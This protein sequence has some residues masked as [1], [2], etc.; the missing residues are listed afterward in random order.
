MK[1][2][3]GRRNELVELQELYDRKI[4]SLA[5]IKG[6]RRVGKSRLVAEFVR[7]GSEN[8]RSKTAQFFNFAGLAPAKGVTSQMQRDHFGRTLSSKLNIPIVTFQD[9]SDAFTFL[10][11]QISPVFYRIIDITDFLEL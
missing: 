4:T 1:S 7:N 3:V 10:S 2:F 11:H 8:Y 5:V 9:W 6:R